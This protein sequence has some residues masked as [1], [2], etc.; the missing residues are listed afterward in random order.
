MNEKIRN[1]ENEYSIVVDGHVLGLEDQMAM[2]E[3]WESG[4]P[5]YEAYLAEL[6]AKKAERDSRI[7]QIA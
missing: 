2:L 4:T 3:A 7:A 5:W 1:I 6:L